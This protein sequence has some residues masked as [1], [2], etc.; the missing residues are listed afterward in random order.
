MAAYEVIVQ[1]LEPMRVVAVS[2]NLAGV[3]S[4]AR[5]VSG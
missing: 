1:R 4:A 3:T 2:E 5:P